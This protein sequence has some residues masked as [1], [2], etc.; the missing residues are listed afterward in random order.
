MYK[1]FIG[2]KFCE[3]KVGGCWS[4][5]ESLQTKGMLTPVKKGRERKI[6]WRESLTAAQFWESPSQ[7]M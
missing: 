7:P 3:G 5:S 1:G 2:E 6:E 4:S